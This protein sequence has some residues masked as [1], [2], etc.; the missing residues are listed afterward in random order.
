MKRI[1]LTHFSHEELMCPRTGEVVLADGFGKELERLRGVFGAP[2]TLTSAC[3][4]AE[5]NKAIG[6]HPRSL[7]IYD[8]PYHPTGGCCAVDI[9]TPDA[10][11]RRKLIRAIEA[12]HSSCA[13]SYGI[14]DSFVHIDMRHRFIDRPIVAFTY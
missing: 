10:H 6:G 4:S 13:W 7:H 8:K 3:R 5:Y 1:D 9:H 12:V 14:A 2:M 11:Y